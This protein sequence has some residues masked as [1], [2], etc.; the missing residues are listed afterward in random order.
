[1][2]TSAGQRRVRAPLLPRCG[3]LAHALRRS[4][5]HYDANGHYARVSPAAANIFSF[6]DPD[7]DGTGTLDPIPPADQFD[8]VDF[9]IFTRC[10]GGS[11]QPASDGST[12]F[13]GPTN[14][15]GLCNPADV[16]PGTF[17]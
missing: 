11:T 2:N 17:P 14:L 5:R 16:P 6:D 15:T 7:S 9:G 8:G 12:P 3:R 13:L 10:P 4:H 1:M